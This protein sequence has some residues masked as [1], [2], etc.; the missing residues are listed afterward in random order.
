M[1]RG[2][3][4][5]VASDSR[6]AL[7]LFTANPATYDLVV[8]AQTMPGLS[9]LQLAARMLEMRPGLPAILCTGYAD[10][11]LESRPEG[12]AAFMPK[13]VDSRAIVGNLVKLLGPG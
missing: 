7:N 1:R 8:T 3:T 4:V 6:G 12:I 2:F 9:G 10:V 5:T 11:A 13:P